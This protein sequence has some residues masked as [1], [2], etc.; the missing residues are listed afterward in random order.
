MKKYVADLKQRPEHVRRNVAVGAAG[1]I[2]GLIAVAWLGLLVS[3]G[4]FTLAPTGQS[5]SGEEASF[6]IAETRN[7]FS[8]FVGAV[9]A[10]FGGESTEPEFTVVDGRTSS[11]LAP[12]ENDTDAT[13]IPF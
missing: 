1:A 2:T 13:V 4:S 12:P 5:F 8:E 10:P 6:E 9:G 7:S 3:S 11:T